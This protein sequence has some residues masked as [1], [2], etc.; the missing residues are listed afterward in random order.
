[1]RTRKYHELRKNMSEK[2]SYINVLLVEN[3]KDSQFLLIQQLEKITA[4]NFDFTIAETLQKSLDCIKTNIHFD[5]IFLDLK[6]PDSTGIDTVISV[7]D[8]SSDIPIIVLTS[9]AEKSFGLLA[10]QHGAQD[11]FIK[12]DYTADSL[13]KAITYSIER[14]KLKKKRS[15]F[16]TETNETFNC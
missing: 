7:T 4:M 6:L 12:G 13:K 14:N 11:F 10:M 2:K 8:V 15:I 16:Q 1:M 5:L 9:L 3:N